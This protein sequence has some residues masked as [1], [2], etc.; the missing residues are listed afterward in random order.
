MRRSKSDPLNRIL[1]AIIT[2]LEEILIL[3]RLRVNIIK[4]T[5]E[6]NKNNMIIRLPTISG[7]KG[8]SEK[9]RRLRLFKTEIM[10][11]DKLNL[12]IPA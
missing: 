2:I 6:I 3:M 9:T 7:G 11:K 5:I 12:D 10:M 4:G 8:I 1:E